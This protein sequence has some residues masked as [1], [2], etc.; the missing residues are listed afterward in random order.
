MVVYQTLW[1]I[2]KEKIIHDQRAHQVVVLTNEI[3]VLY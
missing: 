2:R 3:I 1:C